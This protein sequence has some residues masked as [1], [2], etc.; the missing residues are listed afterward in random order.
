MNQPLVDK[1]VQAVLY[2]GY[3]LYPYRPSVKNHC[4][5]TF[6]GVYPRAYVEANPGADLSA[7]QCQC[8]VAQARDAELRISIRFLHLMLR[9]TESTGQTWQEAV[10]REVPLDPLK[11]ADLCAWPR[12]RSFS[13]AN[14]QSSADSVTREQ[15]AIAG[16]IEL[17]AMQMSDGVYQLTVR[18]ENQTVLDPLLVHNRD[19]ALMRSFASTHMIL[20]VAGGRFISMTDPP[21]PLAGFASQC[22]N[23]GCWPVLAGAARDTDTLLASPIILYDYPQIAPESPGDLFDGTE[24][25]EILSLRIMTLTDREKQ[26][27]ADTDD[28][29]RQMLS[30]TESLARDQMMNLHGVFRGLTATRQP[31]DAAP[32]P[33]E[34]PHG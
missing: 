5:W 34:A 29:V 4:R 6:G 15:Q 17:S 3:I 2:E 10:E 22:R 23:L 7:M 26:Q 16:A 12:S 33:Q 31:A 20:N 9:R 24:I 32:Q 27:A 19:E 13:F 14:S 21:T 30:R 25:D 8:L 28:R 1:I 11:L 18:V